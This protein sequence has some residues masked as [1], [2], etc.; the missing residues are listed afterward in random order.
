VH[1]GGVELGHHN[2][3]CPG[4]VGDGQP[5]DAILETS[6]CVDGRKPV[7]R[8]VAL[9]VGIAVTPVDD[10]LSWDGFFP[11]QIVIESCGPCLYERFI[12]IFL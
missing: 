4:R 8:L 6:A 7:K 11:D 5:E 10:L 2:T 12:P 3:I 9:L 1:V